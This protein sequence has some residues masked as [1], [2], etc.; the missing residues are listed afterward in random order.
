MGI[1]NDF[2]VFNYICLFLQGFIIKNKLKRASTLKEKSIKELNEITSSLT[3]TCEILCTC[4][5]VI[6]NLLYISNVLQK[7]SLIFHS[8]IVSCIQH[9]KYGGVANSR[10]RR[11][12]VKERRW[13]CNVLPSYFEMNT[14][15][16][17][18]TFLA[19]DRVLI[20]IIHIQNP[21][22]PGTKH[23]QIFS[24]STHK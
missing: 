16:L 1:H 12:S 24:C 19:K 6:F 5:Y 22:S 11:T 15:D 8:I 7:M 23:M 18:W 10:A 20:L 21:S 13:Q 3:S 2:C 17:S 4:A 14:F 9:H